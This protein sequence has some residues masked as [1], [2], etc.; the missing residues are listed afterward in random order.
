MYA[1]DRSWHSFQRCAPS[2][3]P[4]YICMRRGVATVTVTAISI[5]VA[6]DA[7][8]VVAYPCVISL[9]ATFSSHFSDDPYAGL[10]DG[11][12]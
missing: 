1:A 8:V 12:T 2:L 9:P 6:S 11:S 7:I 4:L 5:I 10:V 3:P